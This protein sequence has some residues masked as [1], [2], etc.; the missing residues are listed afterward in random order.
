M[1]DRYGRRVL[2]RFVLIH[3]AWH[4]GWCWHHVAPILRAAGHTV[5]TPTLTGLGER[6]HL[7]HRGIDLSLHASDV[8]AVLEM[9][10]L[11]DVVLVGHS[12]A[13]MVI[14]AVAE[15]AAERLHSLIYLDAIVPRNGQSMMDTLDQETR[16][17][18]D[19]QVSTTGEGWKL[20]PST[21]E[22]LGITNAADAAWVGAR[23]VSQPY[24][25]YQEPIQLNNPAAETLQRSY[26]YCSAGAFAARF[27]TFAKQASE[28]PRWHYAE[29]A[30]GHDAMITMPDALAQ[31]LMEMA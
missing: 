16:D 5:Y 20:T 12:Y 26:V 9:E 23:L 8:V 13:G 29:L 17:R 2:A 27:A 3:G 18:R 14:T 1:R 7:A 6:V 25:T 22:H 24:G 11:T 19:A 30:T 21:T 15:R 28:D 10:D 31:V 4:G